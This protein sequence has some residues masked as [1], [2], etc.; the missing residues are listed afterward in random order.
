MR[1]V[2]CTYPYPRRPIVLVRPL[3]ELHI[4]QQKEHVRPSD[5][6]KKTKP[7]K[8]VGLMTSDN[9]AHLDISSQ[10]ALRL[11][12]VSDKSLSLS[13]PQISDRKENCR[14][15]AG[16][17]PS[18]G[19]EFL[20]RQNYIAEHDHVARQRIEIHQNA[21][22]R[23]SGFGRIHDGRHIDEHREQQADDFLKV[24]QRIAQD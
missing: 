23:R 1:A 3:R 19:M 11:N 7:R 8:K 14:R 10:Y 12:H 21:Q 15:S 4:I 5:F 16:N 22:D 20:I 9:H 13:D 6:G 17:N 18:L 2:R 24:A